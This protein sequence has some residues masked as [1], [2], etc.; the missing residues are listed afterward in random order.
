MN[1]YAL[2]PF[3]AAIAYI[4][5]LIILVL[6]RPWQRQHWFFFLYIIPAF[7]WSCVDFVLRSSFFAIDPIPLVQV[8]LCLAIWMGVQAHYFLRYFYQPDYKMPLAYILLISAIALA[9]LGYIPRGVEVISVGIVDVDYSVWLFLLASLLIALVSRDIYLLIQKSKTSVDPIERNQL[10]YLFSAGMVA[11]VFLIANFTPIGASYPLGHLGNFFA[12]CI[13]TYAIVAHQLLDIMVTLRR[14]LSWIWLALVAALAY[15]SLLFLAHFVFDLEFA[16]TL[17]WVIAIIGVLTAVLVYWLSDVSRRKIE[18]IL[19]GERY[20]YRQKLARFSYEA[21]N[22]TNLEVFGSQMVPLLCQS[23]RS[24]RGW[25]LLPW[26]EGGDFMTRFSY[27]SEKANPPP[28]LRLRQDNPLLGWLERKACRLSQRELDIFPEFGALWQEEK[29]SIQSAQVG[30]FFPVMNEGRLVAVLALGKKRRDEFYTLEDLDLVESTLNRVAAP[31]QKEHLREQLMRREEELV[32]LNR[33]VAIITSS[34]NIKEIFEGFLGE[35][36]KITEVDWATIALADGDELYFLALSSVTPSPWQAEERI[37]LSGTGTEWVIK[38]QRG[39]YEP[40][41]V[42]QRRF[43]TGEK[44]IKQGIHS[45]LYLPLIAAGKGIGALVIG[46]RRPQAYNPKQI[47]LLEQ[48]ALQITAPIENSQ[49]YIQT[50]D[51]ARVDELT[52]LF[53]R[54]HFEERLKEEI[55]RHARYGGTFSLL[56]LDLDFFKT[57]NDI[58]GH[59]AGDQLLSQIGRLIKNAIRSTD[60]A[61]RYG[62]DEF[63]ALLPQTDTDSAYNVAERVRQQIALEMVEKAIGVTCS[64]GL[65]NYPVDGIMPVDLV[66]VADTALYHAKHSGGNQCYRPTK[67]SVPA[68]AD[69]T[70][71]IRSTSLAAIYAL[72]AAV[73]A[74]D[75]YTYTHSHKIRSYAVALA[76]AIGLPL[77]AISRISAASLL[78]DIGKI[79]VPDYILTKKEPLTAAEWEEMKAHPRLGA[80]IIANVSSLMPLVSIV[81]Y[82]HE[83]YDGSGYPEGLKGEAIPLEARILAVADA[84][85]AMTSIRPYQPPLSY[86]EAVGELKRR[87]GSQFDPKLVPVFIDV[88]VSM[89]LKKET[90]ET[91]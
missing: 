28:P 70:E 43:W 89:V 27:P 17:T 49:L 74:K 54:R 77:D 26:F 1:S 18:E 31:M 85:T 34:V 56:M 48:L 72:T 75:H 46:S 63:T 6:G 59:P 83:N 14:V 13:L 79:G 12:A 19:T 50:R 22:I 86:E 64:I 71:V 16:S 21:S 55:T 65:A 39:L 47:Q 24:H 60:Q 37:P 25:L 20:A 52:G 90:T 33:L 61:F 76:E 10:R 29:E 5:L 58:Y 66:T 3:L 32:V 53:N 41:L 57:Y 42:K 62:G 45:I 73:D 82:H 7:L 87:A 69:I 2:I 80:N 84:F 30:M 40:N 78:H 88:V 38:E 35:L 68:A 51:R 44:H 91:R 15:F 4:P 81:L 8:I 11:M 9:V 67:V 23:T 36:K